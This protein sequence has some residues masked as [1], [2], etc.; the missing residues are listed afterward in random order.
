MK[1]LYIGRHNCGGND[2][3][4][5]ITHALQTLGHQVITLPEHKGAGKLRYYDTDIVLFNHWTIGSELAASLAPTVFWYFDRVELPDPVLAA[6]S[7]TRRMLI[8][9][10]LQY[11]DLGFMTD[12]D[13]V[14]SDQTGKLH[15]L[16]QGADVRV[17]GYGKSYPAP[18]LLFAGARFHGTQREDHLRELVKTYGD[19]LRIIEGSN[20][21][22]RREL[23]DA[24]ASAK[25]V[26]APESPVTDRYW[27]N[28]VFMVSG[29]GGFLLHPYSAGLAEL[30]RDG[31]EI[32]FYHSREDL[33]EKIAYY[34]DHE[35]ERR[36]IQA[37]ALR[38]T[39][40]EHTYTHRCARLL[41]I[42]GAHRD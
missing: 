42:A 37:E 25:I 15:W 19:R 33:H 22:Y 34:L 30:Y 4:G 24:I 7:A 2:D 27:S 40:A 20:R 23:A 38:R 36:A 6:R 3:E 39:L 13:R 21:I 1:I 41:E 8:N 29:F 14:A 28:R 5:A 17:T 9:T 35:D 26:I 12:G 16:L 31:E 11:V 10:Y 32:V 18:P